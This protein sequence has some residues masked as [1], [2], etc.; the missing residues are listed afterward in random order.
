MK[1]KKAVFAGL[2]L[3]VGAI[4]SCDAFRDDDATLL[5][6]PIFGV[7]E[8][9]QATHTTER[10][11]DATIRTTMVFNAVGGFRDVANFPVC[12][13]L[14][15]FNEYPAA[16][17]DAYASVEEA[18]SKATHHLLFELL[19]AGSAKVMTVS[20]Y[21]SFY[22]CHATQDEL[23]YV[24]GKTTLQ[25]VDG[26]A[27]EYTVAKDG[28]SVTLVGNIK[29]KAN[30]VVVS[31]LD[32]GSDYDWI[33]G[34]WV[35]DTDSSDILTITKSPKSLVYTMRR[36]VGVENDADVPFPTVCRYELKADD[37]T[38]EESGSRVL[39]S[40]DVSEIALVD[41]ANNGSA[42]EKYI[43]AQKVN[44][45]KTSDDF[46]WGLEKSGDSKLLLDGFESYSPAN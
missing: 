11:D 29:D 1:R 13:D 39:F 36:Q 14:N 24:A 22:S 17:S 28:T 9:D 21:E 33:Y 20:T 6:A 34:K 26:S 18:E 25:T 37:Y 2:L 32:T 3:L 15:D 31:V 8:A 45:A 43:A 16:L 44:F 19:S 38:L 27:F 40:F 42:C 41:D 46:H 30:A 4:V 12:P 35:L 10:L 5:D 7:F 23:R